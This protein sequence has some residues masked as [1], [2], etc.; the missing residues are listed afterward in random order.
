MYFEKFPLMQYSL[1]G[2]LTSFTMTDIFRRIKAD[3]AVL[4]INCERVITL[5]C[6]DLGHK[7]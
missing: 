7:G 1:D 4:H 3:K 2:G 6:H 5:L